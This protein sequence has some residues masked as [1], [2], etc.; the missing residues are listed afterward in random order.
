MSD[1]VEEVV[2]SDFSK[3]YEEGNLRGKE[4]G[5]SEGFNRGKEWGKSID[6][7]REERMFI[8]GCLTVVA[9]VVVICWSV[10][11]A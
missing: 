10:L 7:N 4:Q 6:S 8:Y 2:E 3:G 1:K 11:N 9:V 5:W